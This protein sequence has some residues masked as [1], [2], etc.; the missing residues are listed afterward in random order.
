MNKSSNL[1]NDT[2]S[3]SPSSKDKIKTKQLTLFDLKSK[4]ITVNK[5]NDR[6]P[7]VNSTTTTTTIKAAEKRNDLKQ[8]KSSTAH[9]N[10]YFE[11]L[12]NITQQNVTK[13]EVDKK[14]I[15]D[16]PSV[17]VIGGKS[18]FENGQR[19]YLFGDMI[20]SIE[21]YNT[22][23]KLYGQ[24]MD[25]RSL[26]EDVKLPKIEIEKMLSCL[27][28]V[29]SSTDSY[30]YFLSII[31]TMLRMIVNNEK[32]FVANNFSE[33]I[34]FN[35]FTIQDICR[36]V[37]QN[38]LKRL[39]LI[40]D[41]NVDSSVST[42][43]FDLFM[44]CGDSVEENCS[45]ESRISCELF[46]TELN[47]LTFE[48]RL[49][50][51]S[52]LCMRLLNLD[53][54]LNCF[55]ELTAKISEKKS[56]IKEC[57]LKMAEIEANVKASKTTL[58]DDKKYQNLVQKLNKLVLERDEMVKFLNKCARIEPIGFDSEKNT[59]WKFECL[60]DCIIREC[61]NELFSVEDL[62]LNKTKEYDSIV[63]FKHEMNNHELNDLIKYLGNNYKANL[64][65]ISD[66]KQFRKVAPAQQIDEFLIKKPVEP[67][68]E[69]VDIE[70]K[71]NIRR[72]TR[73]ASKVT[74]K[75]E[76][77]DSDEDEVVT[78][79]NESKVSMFDLYNNLEP[80]D[81]LYNILNHFNKHVVECALTADGYFSKWKE[82]CERGIK[83]VNLNE[84][85][86]TLKML[87]QETVKHLP[88]SVLLVNF[89]QS[90]FYASIQESI[91]KCATLSN[92]YMIIK[93]LETNVKSW[94]AVNKVKVV[95]KKIELVEKK[96]I[97]ED[98][99]KSELVSNSSRRRSTRNRQIVNLSND[100][101]SSES[102]TESDDYS[103]SSLS[104]PP[105]KKNTLR[106]SE[107]RK[108]VV[109][110]SYTPNLRSSRKQVKYAETTS[111]DDE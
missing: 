27:N 83:C 100:S 49:D 54:F 53:V 14:I 57:K 97:I 103:E 60:S 81:A 7:G 56:S 24:I 108:S 67:P 58:A 46:K 55:S 61:R 5:E 88:S 78:S 44:H 35:S 11:N 3:R 29:D 106:K 86:E 91:Q 73:L 2:V 87:F 94:K 13:S 52:V 20:M 18:V 59:Y 9:N 21:L 96:I 50:L 26:Q 111:S 8:E 39:N 63:W 101:T 4:S 70:Q 34:K 17:S 76:E 51:I 31:E 107:R 48:Q 65:L 82:Q 47:K 22:Y 12:I 37:I 110:N 89:S 33:K 15:T 40:E 71:F 45:D 16:A 75:F 62:M 64:K 43:V 28:E 32:N 1:L 10:N 23:V 36:V 38:D 109:N 102:K 92:F 99:P 72:S 19:N 74:T 25:E 80:L 6:L 79:S 66:L 69:V 30:K 42:S 95:Q 93:I 104:P 85:F 90:A 41:T 105:G 68:A 77:N 98:K 84:K